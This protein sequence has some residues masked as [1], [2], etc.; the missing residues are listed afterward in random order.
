[1]SM[2]V[3]AQLLSIRTWN[4]VRRGGGLRCLSSYGGVQLYIYVCVG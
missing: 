1:M 3:G 2:S 4:G